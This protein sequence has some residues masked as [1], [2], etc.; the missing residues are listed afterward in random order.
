MEF[1]AKLQNVLDKRIYLQLKI[2]SEC[3]VFTEASI[4]IL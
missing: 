2:S 3:N 1:V 4:H